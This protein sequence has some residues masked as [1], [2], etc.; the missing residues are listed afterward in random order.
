MI[1][2]LAPSPSNTAQRAACLSQ[3]RVEKGIERTKGSFERGEKTRIVTSKPA[4]FISLGR[5][6]CPTQG[7][8]LSSFSVSQLSLHPTPSI[9][10]PFR[11]IIHGE[12]CTY[13]PEANR[14]REERKDGDSESE[15]RER[16]EKK[17][18]GP[19]VSSLPAENRMTDDAFYKI[20]SVLE[21]Q[22]L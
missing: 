19:G 3:K 13:V 9:F 6:H 15:E 12:V 8:P 14:I 2:P 1:F 10:F 5:N 11:L 7:M 20:Y 16:E 17:K 4:S 22:E 18:L 21:W